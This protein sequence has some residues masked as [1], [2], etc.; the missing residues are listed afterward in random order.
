MESRSFPQQRLSNSSAT[1]D[2]QPLDKEAR[3]PRAVK[4][5]PNGDE[6]QS[7]L[8]DLMIQDNEQSKRKQ[9]RQ[10]P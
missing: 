9:W 2:R 7:D 5:A 3:L 4:N 10:P 6:I 8:L 1:R